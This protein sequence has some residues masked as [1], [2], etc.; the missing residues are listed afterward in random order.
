MDSLTQIVLG[1]AV[2]EIALGRKIGNRALIWGAIGG[3]IPDLDVLANPFMDDIRALAFHRSISHS[4]FFSVL[5]PLVFG[6]LIH[7]L[8]E[9]KFHK[10]KFYKALITVLNAGILVGI[11]F[12]INYMVSHDG[13][14]L[15]WFLFV[16][17]LA[18]VF[19]LM[20]LYHHYMIKELEAPQA[21]FKEWYLLFFLAFFTH[22]LLD[23]FTAFGTQIFQPFSNYR[24]AFNNIAVID[25]L[26]TVPFLICIIIVAALKRNTHKRALFNRIGLGVSSLYMVLTIA[27]KCH[28]D[29]VFSLALKHR[30]IEAIRYRTGPTILNN[31]LWTCVAEDQ[32]QYYVG[33]YS[34]FDSDPNLHYLN[35]LPKNDSL[36]RAW[37]ANEEYRTL[38]WFSDGYLAA[39][40]TDT[41][42]WLSDLRYGGMTDT[43][44][45]QRDLVFNFKVKQE[46][47]TLSFSENREPPKGNFGEILRR[48]FTRMKGY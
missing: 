38:Q 41:V 42:T 43:I 33:L 20:R 10:T 21:T 19:L 30:N 8:Y 29:K 7:R 37:S 32:H 16:S 18:A 23:C 44:K 13:Y 24:V 11:T 40:P 12:G 27:N 47:G 22:W 45:D 25:P 5:A 17:G 2:G 35:I 26:Y 46:N 36:Q 14:P 34:I 28:V 6:G 48:F 9:T 4:I 15:W 39:F 1:A 31:L 3:T